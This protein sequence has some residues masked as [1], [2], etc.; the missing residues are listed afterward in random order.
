MGN[1]STA[2]SMLLPDN[3]QWPCVLSAETQAQLLSIAKPFDYRS[4]TAPMPGV[5]Y[6]ESGCLVGY[7]TNSNIDTSLGLIFGHGTW[8]GI[9]SINNPEYASAEIYEALLP[10]RLFVLPKQEVEAMLDSNPEIY[11]F[12]F[13]IAQQRGRVSLQMASNTLFCL[14]TRVVY[15][16]LE[17]ITKHNFDNQQPQ[18]IHITQ[19]NLSHIVGISRPRVNEVLKM[20]A[21]AEEIIIKRGK[22]VITDYA[23]LK[24]RLHPFSLMY[25]DP[26]P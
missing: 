3:I 4:L 8:F 20:L 14:T 23:K 19:Q 22:I 5:L 10:T 18:E 11:K 21:D 17:L 9:Q 13:Y 1:A 16:L 6:V 2:I 15:I 7:A 12:L 24:T 25:H 26:A